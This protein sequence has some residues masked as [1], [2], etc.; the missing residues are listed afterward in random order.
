M[1]NSII[2]LS[3]YRFSKAKEDLKASEIMLKES[4]YKAAINRSYYAIFHAV[5]AV[6]VLHGFDSSKHSGVIAYFNQ[7]FVKTNIFDKEVSKIIKGASLIREKSDYQ[8]F[9]ITSRKDAEQQLK[10]AI[11]FVDMV[12]DYLKHETVI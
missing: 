9:F 4:M 12:E 11:T 5:R 8:D 2:E 3:A 6:T 1:E 7:N 10:N